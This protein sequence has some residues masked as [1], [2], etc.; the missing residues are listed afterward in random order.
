MGP[1]YGVTELPPEWEEWCRDRPPSVRQALIKF[2]PGTVVEDHDKVWHYVIGYQDDGGLL[3]T[4][5][6]P[7]L[8]WDAA[9]ADAK[10]MCSCCMKTLV[11]MGSLADAEAD[12]DIRN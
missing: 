10:P 6:D 5:I 12:R 11:L 1:I 9:V 4:K 3:V 8:A 7:Q 2:P